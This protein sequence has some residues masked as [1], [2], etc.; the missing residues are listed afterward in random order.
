MPAGSARATF[1]A[2]PKQ[3][4]TE[5]LYT[6]S[7]VWV[8]LWT[9]F[10]ISSYRTMGPAISCGKQA[11]YMPKSTRLRAGATLRMYTSAM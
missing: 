1:L 3:N 6:S 4:C 8:R 2:S 10:S 9:C 7:S 11:W 5:P